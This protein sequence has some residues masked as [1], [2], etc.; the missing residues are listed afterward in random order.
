MTPAAVARPAPRRARAAALPPDERRQ[1]IVDAAIPLLVEHGSGVTTRQIAEA[2]G[3]AEGTLFR[4]FEDKAALLHAAA[5]GVL[6]PEWGRR[7]LA[8]VDADLSLEAMVGTVAELLLQRTGQVMAV[9]MALRATQAPPEVG[10]PGGQG[11]PQFVLESHRALL[12]GVTELF[13]RYR[14]ELRVAPERA[15]LTLRALVFGSRQ[16]WADQSLS[17]TGPEIAA[18]LLTGIAA[19]TPTQ[20]V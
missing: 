8:E 1:A 15:A 14:G 2:A 12:E 9:L 17:L 6:D 10:R 4:V 5:H 16:P 3:V 7:S 18:V 13:G 11:P 20:E 19:H